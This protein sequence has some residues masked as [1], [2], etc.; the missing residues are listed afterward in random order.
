[1]QKICTLQSK[2]LE[3]GPP[4]PS[5]IYSSSFSQKSSPISKCERALEAIRKDEKDYK[6]TLK[7]YSFK[8]PRR[9]AS[10]S[11]QIGPIS[12]SNFEEDH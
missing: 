8:K 3:R 4:F 5:P 9:Q 6:G 7:R 11:K 2:S 12:I 1:L 10:F